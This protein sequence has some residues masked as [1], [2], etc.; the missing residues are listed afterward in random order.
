MSESEASAT[1]KITAE[2]EVITAEQIKAEQEAAAAGEQEED[3]A[4]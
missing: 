3:E 2:A 4:E 1:T